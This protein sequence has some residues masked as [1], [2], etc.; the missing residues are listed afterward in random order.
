[1]SADITELLTQA[2]NEKAETEEKVQAPMD[3]AAVLAASGLVST[4]PT[5][6]SST[7]I[8][9]VED[10]IPLMVIA[11][12]FDDP[13]IKDLFEKTEI[14][15]RPDVQIEFC[16]KNFD[17]KYLPI[18]SGMSQDYLA[19]YLFFKITSEEAANQR[20]AKIC[21]LLQIQQFLVSNPEGG[22]CEC[23]AGH[24]YLRIIKA[25]QKPS[26]SFRPTCRFF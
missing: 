16:M 13:Q 8:V 11:D 5:Q 17:G 25:K 23:S 20:F 3:F 19:K 18:G 12:Q 22:L 24:V 10:K 2:G 15:I 14:T 7:Y 26:T 9:P 21:F 4:K 1:M 6:E